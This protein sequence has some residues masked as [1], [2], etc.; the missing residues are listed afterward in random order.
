[1]IFRRKKSNHNPFHYRYQHTGRGAGPRHRHRGKR[2]E[3]NLSAFLPGHQR[4]RTGRAWHWPGSGAKPVPPAQRHHGY[5]I[6]SRQR[7][8]RPHHSSFAN[9]I[10]WKKGKG[11]FGLVC[12]GNFVYGFQNEAAGQP[13]FF[14]RNGKWWS[15]AHAVVAE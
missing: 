13:Y 4:P 11:S 2:T 5:S 6:G 7:N 12:R 8:N 1:E 15:Y 10:D 14:F 9:L 3:A